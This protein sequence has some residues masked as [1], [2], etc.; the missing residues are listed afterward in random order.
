MLAI[1]KAVSDQTRLSLLRE[2]AK[3]P[4][5][6]CELPKKV[7]KTQ[8]AVSQHLA[9]LLGAGLVEMKRDGVKRIY[10]VSGLGRKVLSG[11]AS[12]R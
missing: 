12:W 5:C 2:I 9:V 6:A 10:S 7:K 8:P 1:L 4:V 3:R 11:I